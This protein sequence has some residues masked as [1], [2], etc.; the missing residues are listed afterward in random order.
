MNATPGTMYNIEFS[1]DAPEKVVPIVVGLTGT[2]YI[3]SEVYPVVS[4]NKIPS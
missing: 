1:N 2:Y 4:I 3:D